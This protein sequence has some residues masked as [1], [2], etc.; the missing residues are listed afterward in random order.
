[1]P[2]IGELASQFINWAVGAVGESSMRIGSVPTLVTLLIPLVV[3][4]LVAR[5][6]RRWAGSE[7]GALANMAR[8][9]ALAA[10]SG[11]DVVVSLGSAGLVRGASAAER[12]QTL[13]ALPLLGHF[14]RAAARAG[15][16]V[17][18]ASN[19]PLVTFL[20]QGTLDESHRLTSTRERSGSSMVTYIGEG[21][22]LAAAAALAD[23]GGHG[24][25]L[26]AGGLAEEGLMLLS[27]LSGS[28]PWSVGATASP[29]E[30]AGPLL[31]DDG[32]VVGPELFQALAEVAPMAHSRTTVIAANRL[33]V[34]IVVAML[35]GSLAMLAGAPDLAPFLVGR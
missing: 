30:L 5:P 24:V 25:V 18:V 34:G 1:M 9:M 16:P 31:L 10:E 8:A 3:L 19:D 32:A 33:I 7:V 4:S 11:K 17:H 20:A 28:A 6:A 26:V 12:L 21:R 2:N 14:A 29:A 35:L 15:V 23:E 22:P 27:G 13:V